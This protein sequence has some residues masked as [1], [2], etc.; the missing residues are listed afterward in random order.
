MRVSDTA[1]SST[2]GAAAEDL[3]P[4]ERRRAFLAR[5]DRMSSEERLRAARFEFD[6][7]ERSIWAGRYPE[8]AP[9]VDGE[10]EWIGLRLADNLD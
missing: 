2:P 6:R 10:V 7:T 8:E 9:T 4:A 5:L 1:S 3:P